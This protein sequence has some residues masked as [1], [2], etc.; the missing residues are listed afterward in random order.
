MPD[1]A[2]KLHYFTHR[3]FLPPCC[4]IIPFLLSCLIGQN[5]QAFQSLPFDMASGMVMNDKGMS[6]SLESKQP[7]EQLTESV[8]KEQSKVW[9]LNHELNHSILLISDF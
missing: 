2:R 9:S 3:L 7:G 4:R 1:F 5:T 6:Y 8:E